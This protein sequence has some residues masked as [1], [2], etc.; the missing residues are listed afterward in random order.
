M[1]QQ[2]SLQME[3]RSGMKSDC[4]RSLHGYFSPLFQNSKKYSRTNLK[5]SEWHSPNLECTRRLIL[6]DRAFFPPTTHE[7][8]SICTLHVLH[9]ISPLRSV[10]LSRL[11]RDPRATV[12]DLPARGQLPGRHGAVR[13]GPEGR[14]DRQLDEAAKQRSCPGDLPPAPQGLRLVL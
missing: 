4:D 10:A 9:D 8:W 13:G 14:G 2:P 6:L 12:L 1:P 7:V 5:I 11:A 3:L